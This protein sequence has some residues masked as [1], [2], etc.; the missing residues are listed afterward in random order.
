MSHPISMLVRRTSHAAPPRELRTVLGYKNVDLG[1]NQ[2]TLMA[3]CDASSREYVHSR[4]YRSLVCSQTINPWCKERPV[5][6]T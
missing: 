2:N 3:G 5:A 6:V 4:G 1:N